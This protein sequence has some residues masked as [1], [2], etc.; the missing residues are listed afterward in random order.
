MELEKHYSVQEIATAW[1][2][3]VAKVRSMFE[4]LPGVLKFKSPR[5]LKRQYTTLRIPES[6]LR[7][8]YLDETSGFRLPEVKS[9]RRVV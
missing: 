7:R 3:S 1:G 9:R 8:F 4:F 5:L 2:I 6:V